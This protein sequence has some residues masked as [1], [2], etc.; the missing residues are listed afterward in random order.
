MQYARLGSPPANIK[1]KNTAFGLHSFGAPFFC[2]ASRIGPPKAK[3]KFIRAAVT[4]L[5][6]QNTS[7]LATEVRA[8]VAPSAVSRLRPATAQMLTPISTSATPE[9]AA[10]PAELRNLSE[11]SRAS[12]IRLPTAAERPKTTEKVR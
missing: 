9:T 10:S 4:P 7:P 11:C 6:A 2:A 8:L 5:R 12:G 3:P 1:G